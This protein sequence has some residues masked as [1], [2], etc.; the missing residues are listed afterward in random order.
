MTV[1][2][3]TPTRN[4]RKSEAA[5][6][7][8]SFARVTPMHP[9]SGG[10]RLRF[11][12]VL[13]AIA[14]GSWLGARPASAQTTMPNCTGDMLQATLGISVTQN[15]GTSTVQSQSTSKVFSNA[16]CYC[17]TSDLQLQ[18]RATSQ[19]AANSHPGAIIEFWVGTGCENSTTR[20]S[21]TQTTCERLAD[22]VSI[23]R[24]TQYGAGS[25]SDIFIPIPADKLMSPSPTTGIHTCESPNPSSKIY[26]FVYESVDAPLVSCSLQLNG[27]VSAAS[28]PPPAQA[29]Q[30]SGGDS[31]VSIAW[32]DPPASGVVPVMYQVL[33]ANAAGEPIMTAKRNKYSTCMGNG[34]MRRR[35]LVT[36][37]SAISAT[38]GGVDGGSADLGTKSISDEDWAARS[39]GE[40][41]SAATPLA[42]GGATSNPGISTYSGL[43]G[44]VFE[45]L[46]PAYVCTEEIRTTNATGKYRFEDLTNGESYQFVVVAIDEYGNAIPSDLYTAV[47][48][49]VEDLYT[50]Y[51]NQGGT[52]AGFCFIATAA[53]GSYEHRYVRV[54]REFRDRVLLP[55]AIG[56]RFVEWYYEHSPPAAEYIAHHRAARIATQLALWPVILFAALVLYVPGWLLVGV[57]A[58]APALL[59]VRRLRRRSTRAV[60]AC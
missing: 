32:D 21:A 10:R 27:I 59:A 35:E 38:D 13:G 42:D 40:E 48:T 30:V 19:F 53:F 39:G 20:T 58:L 25:G 7:L 4:L 50:R 49:P 51:R 29:V 15:G 18:I 9:A 31:A 44:T 6:T 33:C 46:D 45:H 11:A 56:T 2:A 54:L 1:T 23:S 3:P 16:E 12:A 5:S 14:L 41:G 36:N 60:Q 57:L 37:S 22:T 8:Q 17:A 55:T 52:A 24:L 34:D 47:P 43:A 28:M 26:M